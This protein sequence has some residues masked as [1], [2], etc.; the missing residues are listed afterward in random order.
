[1]ISQVHIGSGL[2][3]RISPELFKAL[4]AHSKVTD[5]TTITIPTVTLIPAQ[6]VR[7]LMR[8]HRQLKP[9]PKAAVLA[10]V[11][12]VELPAANLLESLNPK[13]IKFT[14]KGKSSWATPIQSQDIVTY[15]QNVGRAFCNSL[16][17]MAEMAKLTVALPAKVD[18]LHAIAE[19]INDRC[20]YVNLANSEGGDPWRSLG[21]ITRDD[22]EANSDYEFL[23]G[24][25]KDNALISFKPS[26]P[27]ELKL[28]DNI[29]PTN[30][31]GIRVYAATGEVYDISD[32]AKFSDSVKWA[33]YSYEV[34][35]YEGSGTMLLALNDGTFCFQSLNHCS[36]YGP[37]DDAGPNAPFYTREEIA[38]K[39][40]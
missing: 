32:L 1:M 36:C 27:T 24:R 29:K 13:P 22:F 38:K 7:D 15:A 28:I 3:G 6:A 40:R 31:D 30:V 9:A 10:A 20:F 19:S 18:A 23:T 33:A 25:G 35:D 26:N 14:D 21:G 2:V 11:N 39:N 34:G 12:A 16:Y 37:L 5:G 8:V 17:D 4:P